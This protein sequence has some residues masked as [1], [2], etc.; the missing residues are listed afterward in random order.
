MLNEVKKQDTIMSIY[1][2]KYVKL[3][4][5][6]CRGKWREKYTKMMVG[7][8]WVVEVKFSK[9]P[10]FLIFFIFQSSYREPGLFI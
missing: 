9:L 8:S 4:Q 1:Y 10:F 7:F 2:H 5:G 3:N 6:K